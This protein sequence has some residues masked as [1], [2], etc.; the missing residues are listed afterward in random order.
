MSAWSAADVPASV[1]TVEKAFLQAALALESVASDK[2]TIVKLEGGARRTDPTIEL[3]DFRDANDVRTVLV[4]AY[5][6]IEPDA[7]V[8][9]GKL[10]TKA[11][12]ISTANIS[13]NY[14]T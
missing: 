11:L 8:T 12:E 1:N 13:A 2:E 7:D 5:I 9:A 10:F 14:K 6:P 4:V 3:R